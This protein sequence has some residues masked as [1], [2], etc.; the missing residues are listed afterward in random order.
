[1]ND[2]VIISYE[3]FNFILYYVHFIN[4]YI[5]LHM[6]DDRYLSTLKSYVH[7]RTFLEGSI[8]ERCLAK[9]CTT[10]YSRYLNDVEIKYNHNDRNFVGFNTRGDERGYL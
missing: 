3:S 8:V 9:E 6:D 7:N 4:M 2:I 5:G 10:F 1:M